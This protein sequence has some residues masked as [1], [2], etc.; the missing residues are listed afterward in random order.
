MQIINRLQ[1][2]ETQIN[3]KPC[4]C[5]KTLLDLWYGDTDADDL[6]YCSNCKD[7]YDF[8]VNLAIDAVTSKNLTDDETL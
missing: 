4:F 2:L 8:W 3:V 1:K 5:G 6:T 7:K